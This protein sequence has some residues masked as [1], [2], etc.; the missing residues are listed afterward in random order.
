MAHLTDYWQAVRLVSAGV[1]KESAD[2]Y[3]SKHGMDGDWKMTR[4]E[5]EFPYVPC[6]SLSNLWSLLHDAATTYEFSTEMSA[7]VLVEA[8]VNAIVKEYGE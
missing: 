5:P 7:D 6:W 3:F 8:M 1:P 2:Y 4:T